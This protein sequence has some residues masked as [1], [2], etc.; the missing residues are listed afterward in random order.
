MNLKCVTRFL[1]VRLVLN[2]YLCRGK[3][4]ENSAVGLWLLQ[5]QYTLIAQ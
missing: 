4:V 1:S 5:V 3:N 2:N